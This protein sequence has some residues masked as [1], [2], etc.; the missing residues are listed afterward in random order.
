MALQES[1]SSLGA[2]GTLRGC[3]GCHTAPVHPSLPS[4]SSAVCRG[5][6]PCA[7][8][9]VRTDGVPV[10]YHTSHFVAFPEREPAFLVHTLSFTEYCQLIAKA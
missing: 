4:P 1:S 6:Q 5:L 8:T 3:P 7:G 2:V 9:C 10:F